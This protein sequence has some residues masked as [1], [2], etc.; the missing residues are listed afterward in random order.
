MIN[1]KDIKTAIKKKNY[2]KAMKDIINAVRE[3]MKNVVLVELLEKDFIEN[4][5]L[6]DLIE[7][8]KMMFYYTIKPTYFEKIGDILYRQ[9]EYSEALDNYLNC[10]EGIG[11]YSQIYKKLADVFEKLN[12]NESSL[13]CL[14]QAELIEG[15]K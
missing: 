9:E 11:G 6:N 4:N 3:D 7:M 14:K 2:Q 1:E 5:L 8:Y 13:A 10:A 15:A 12:D